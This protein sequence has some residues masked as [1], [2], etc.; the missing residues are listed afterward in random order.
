MAFCADAR[1]RF[2][3]FE[4]LHVVLQQRSPLYRQLR[5][6]PPSKRLF[7]INQ[8]A[9]FVHERRRDLDIYLKTLLRCGQGFAWANTGHQLWLYRS[10][11]RCCLGWKSVLLMPCSDASL[12]P[13]GEH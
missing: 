9:A 13:P 10:I 5:L 3:N 2:R 8:D 12:Q 7:S 11:D 1:R 6:A 4:A